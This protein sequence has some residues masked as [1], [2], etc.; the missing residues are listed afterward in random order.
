MIQLK[1]FAM[2]HDGRAEKEVNE[3]MK[4]KDVIDIKVVGLRDEK[5]GFDYLSYTVIYNEKLEEKNN[6]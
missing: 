3:F 6:E 4:D 5:F 1:S 2:W